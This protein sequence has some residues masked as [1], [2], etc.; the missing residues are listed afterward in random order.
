MATKLGRR[1]SYLKGIL[2][3]QSLYSLISWFL[4]KPDK[5]KPLY[6]NYNSVYGHK[7]G[8]MLTHL[9]R[10]IKLFDSLTPQPH[11]TT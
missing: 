7:L 10:P 1:V 6:L 2:S 3:K 8:R 9:D 11:E 5:L 4:R